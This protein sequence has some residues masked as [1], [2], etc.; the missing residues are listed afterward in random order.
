[1]QN[2]FFPLSSILPS[3]QDIQSRYLLDLSS[4]TDIQKTIVS[5]F[6][7][8]LSLSPSSSSPPPPS[9]FPP[10]PSSSL[11]LSLLLPLVRSDNV[12]VIERMEEFY[13]ER[14]FNCPF[15]KGNEDQKAFL[16]ISD[17]YI[18]MFIIERA[19]IPQ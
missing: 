8:L 5:S 17:D 14:M 19:C 4:F 3:L 18:G 12:G 1:M 6:L 11:L 7:L 15:F 10:P 2:I 13:K 16:N 9:S